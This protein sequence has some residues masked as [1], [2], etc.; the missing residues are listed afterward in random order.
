MHYASFVAKTE[1]FCDCDRRDVLRTDRC[2]HAV[3]SELMKSKVEKRSYRVGGVPMSPLGGINGITQLGGLDTTKAEPCE[4]NKPICFGQGDREVELTA[5]V[6][7]ST[8]NSVL[9]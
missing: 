3:K 1:P 4:S 8:A 2:T 9:D 5:R 7:L 6:L